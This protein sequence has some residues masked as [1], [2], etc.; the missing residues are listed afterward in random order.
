MQKKKYP[1]SVDLVKLKK[2]KLKYIIFAKHLL[3]W[4]VE[5]ADTVLAPTA[6]IFYESLPDSFGFL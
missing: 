1:N 6:S 4:E 3:L 2:V 5:C